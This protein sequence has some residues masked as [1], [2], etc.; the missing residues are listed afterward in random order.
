MRRTLVLM[1]AVLIG[2]GLAAPGPALA[3]GDPASDYLL[4]QP[5]FYPF[6]RPA[7]ELVDQLNRNVYA[8]KRAGY[9]L[10][11]AIIREPSDLGA[12]PQLFGKPQLY[13]RFL[14]QE[15]KGY[16]A[17]RLLIVMPQGYGMSVRGTTDP[18]GVQVLSRVP[19]PAGDS[20]DQLTTAAVAAVRRLSAA[21]GHPL[22]ANPPAP[23]SSSNPASSSTQPSRGSSQIV[24]FLLAGGVLLVG[25]MAAAAV[26]LLS[27][28]TAAPE[29]DHGGPEPES[30]DGATQEPG[31]ANGREERQ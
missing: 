19:A 17:G 4:L 10:R 12:V 2:S 22:P 24:T 1:A 25:A 14:G 6:S 8:A 28:R 7:P 9:E 3:D 27:R 21:A 5:V 15:L 26:I 18:G 16:Y 31:H 20:P 11:V 13:A 23:P 29:P 30:V